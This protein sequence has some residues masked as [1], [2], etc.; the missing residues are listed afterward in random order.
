MQRLS[1]TAG[2]EQKAKLL[3]L[4]DDP[5][6]KHVFEDIQASGAEAMEKYWCA[7]LV[8]SRLFGTRG[9]RLPRR[10]QAQPVR[11]ACCLDARPPG[12]TGPPCGR[13]GTT[14]S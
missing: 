1:A 13:A 10:A 8:C 2:P 3:L 7:P 12:L 14:R 9:A 11:R 5:E 4:K 6:L